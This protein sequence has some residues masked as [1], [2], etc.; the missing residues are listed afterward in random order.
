MK[1]YCSLFFIINLA[2]K[3]QKGKKE[4]VLE[5]INQ[6]VSGAFS[7]ILLFENGDFVVARIKFS[8][9]KAMESYRASYVKMSTL[10]EKASAKGK[11]N[12]KAT[13]E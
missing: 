4:L 2:K 3:E 13:R 7:S 5:N 11:N 12:E 6:A 8:C 10:L 9:Q 1:L